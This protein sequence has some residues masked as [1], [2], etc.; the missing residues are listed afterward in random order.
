MF[1]KPFIEDNDE[2]GPPRKRINTGFSSANSIT[3]ESSPE[4]KMS[5]KSPSHAA[6]RLASPD[7][8]VPD[9]V[10]LLSNSSLKTRIV[11][12]RRPDSEPMTGVPDSVELTTLILTNPHH[13][14]ARVICAFKLC[15]GDPK[16]ANALIQDLSWNHDTPGTS[17]TGSPSASVTP[18]INDSVSKRAAEKE[19][20]KK[21]M[22]YAKR[23]GAGVSTSQLP[24]LARQPVQASQLVLESPVA[25]KPAKRKAAKRIINSSGSEAD[26]SD[27]Q[28]SDNNDGGFTQ[29]R[30]DQYYYDEALKWLNECEPNGLVELAGQLV[31][32]P[33]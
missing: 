10:E 31:R 6:A 27:G 16:A 19:K 21:S 3:V 12:G 25:P 9:A 17:N 1:P 4:T 33:F 23:Q 14:R 2:E 11:R 18:T 7:S 24:A 20:G 26:Y 30:E 5:F 15:E 22:I 29:S 28:D 13:S 8:D 32:N